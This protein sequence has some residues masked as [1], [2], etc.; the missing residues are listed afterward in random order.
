MP[1][2]KLL[3]QSEGVAVSEPSGISVG[4]GEKNY[5]TSPSAVGT[6]WAASGA[7]VTVADTATAS[8]M[9]RANT[10]GTAIKL[11]AV[12]GTDYMRGRWTLDDVDVSRPMHAKFDQRVIGALATGD[13]K[14]EVYY[15]TDSTYATGLTEQALATDVSGTSSLPAL[16]LQYITSWTPA[17]TALYWEIRIVRVAGTAAIGLSDFVIGPGS[18]AVGPCVSE[19]YS[20]TPTFNTDTGVAV[21]L[22]ATG[23]VDPTGM[24]RRVGNSIEIQVGMQNG[25]GGAASA[26]SGTYVYFGLPT[27]L[28]ANTSQM[29]NTLGG[30]RVVGNGQINVSTKNGPAVFDNT[31]GRGVS[32]I[33][34]SDN[35]FCTLADIIANIRMSIMAVIP[36]TEWSGG[37]VATIQDQNLNEWQDYTPTGTWVSNA[38][39]TGKWRRVGQNMEIQAA[40]TLTGAP[41]AAALRIGLPT[42]YVIDHSALIGEALG[43]GQA[44]GSAVARD[45]GTADYVGT[46]K[47]LSA[48]TAGVYISSNG[49]AGE[50]S[51]TIPHTWAVNDTLSI[52]C[53]VPIVEWSG[54]SGGGALGYGLATPDA[55]GIVRPSFEANGT[56]QVAY[57]ATKPVRSGTYTPTYVE[58]SPNNLDSNPTAGANTMLWSQV[59]RIVYCS[60]FVA[61]DPT[62][63]NTASGFTATLPVLPTS[64]FTA[65]EEVAGVCMFQDSGDGSIASGGTVKGVI[66]SKTALIS[67]Y[68]TEPSASRNLFYQFQYRL[69]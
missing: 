46:V 40:I 5:A 11:T 49:A 36:I 66:S 13:F 39:Y 38:T 41:T 37:T 55:A 2:L 54:R 69:N 68:A 64:N 18:V 9:P 51:S 35:D 29:I 24:W 65:T 25:S 45:S 15:T 60:G 31:A 42:G 34:G 1:E 43:S 33:D 44:V 7:G 57:D 59:G 67:F 61:V 14:V 17:S 30:Y 6:F 8:E 58:S 26:A 63:D 52:F 16:D 56:T 28:T 10:S 47:V 20:Y 27:G 22:N 21:T 32:F 19:W 53:S 4:S 62:L 50:W 23:K 12:S 3:Q 48:S